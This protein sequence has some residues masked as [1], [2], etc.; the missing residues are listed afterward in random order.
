MDSAMRWAA[1]SED[2]LQ[3]EKTNSTKEVLWMRGLKLVKRVSG[4]F[5]NNNTDI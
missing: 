1:H 2:F 3:E 5:F 4:S